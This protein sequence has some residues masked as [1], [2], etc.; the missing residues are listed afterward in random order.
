M[1]KLCIKANF[2]LLRTVA[3]RLSRVLYALWALFDADCIDPAASFVGG[4]AYSAENH[5]RRPADIHL[6]RFAITGNYN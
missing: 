1:N 5:H 6:S 2:V 4:Q 3:H